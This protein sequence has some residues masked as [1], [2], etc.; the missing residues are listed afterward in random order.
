MTS[1]APEPPLV[2]TLSLR[3]GQRC[4]FENMPEDI[5]DEIDEYALE[6][7]FVSDPARGVD[8]VHIF[9]SEP[10]VLAAKLPQF[11]TQIA[12]DGQIWVSWSRFDAERD[13]GLNETNVLQIGED[14]GLVQTKACTLN[15]EWAAMKFVIPKAER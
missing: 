14:A 10:E 8:A 4:W 2:K 9:E 3:D 12:K 1:P 13:S 7:R 5:I 15:A 6:L 11:K